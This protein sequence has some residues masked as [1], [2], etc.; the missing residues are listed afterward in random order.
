MGRPRIQTPEWWSNEWEEVTARMIMPLS[1]KTH[2]GEGGRVAVVGGS[3]DYCGAP[4]FAAMAALRSGSD[5][6]NV[7]CPPEAGRAIK[8]YS[9]ELVV[10]AYLEVYE[11]EAGARDT[12]ISGPG[13]LGGPE[14]KPQEK[15]TVPPIALPDRPYSVP[16]PSAPYL[17]QL[18]ASMARLSPWLPRFDV[19]VV[20]PGLGRSALALSIAAGTVRA[21][22]EADASLVLDA[23]ALW[24]LC[25]EPDLVRGYR[26]AILTPN[27]VELGRLRAAL[28]SEDFRRA[29]AVASVDEAAQAAAEVCS[30]LDG[31]IVLSKGELDQVFAPSGEQGV[32][33]RFTV[34]AEGSARRAGG[35]GDVLAGLLGT[36]VAHNSLRV[37]RPDIWR[38]SGVGRSERLEAMTSLSPLVAPAVAAC[39]VVHHAAAAAFRQAKRGMGAPDVIAN[40][41]EV[42]GSI[43]DSWHAKDAEQAPQEALL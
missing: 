34:S 1:L 29:R 39:G 17:G 20:G 40:L 27:A 6:S 7:F 8:A 25:S 36:F 16:P 12:A 3:G 38:S 15:G 41:A 43:E 4:Y 32:V 2:K 31:P 22:R 26:N 23:D 14:E 35:Q 28:R 5:L 42:I 13:R 37:R 19:F 24:M 33:H 18:E 21:A 9:P 30:A 10:H 11:D